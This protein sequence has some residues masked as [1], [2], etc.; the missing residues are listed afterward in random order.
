LTT[1]VAEGTEKGKDRDFYLFKLIRNS[2]V[3]SVYSVVEKVFSGIL[4]KSRVDK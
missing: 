1:E 2:S 4:F 3:N